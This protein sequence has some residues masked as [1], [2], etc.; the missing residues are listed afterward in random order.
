MATV[1]MK[2]F[3]VALASLALLAACAAPE[4][5]PTATPNV[6]GQGIW[7][8]QSKSLREMFEAS[9]LVVVAEVVEVGA[10]KV[11]DTVPVDPKKPGIRNLPK[12]YFTNVTI[13]VTEDLGKSV[14]P[15]QELTI[16]LPGG[17]STP[18]FGDNPPYAKGE[19]YLLFIKRSPLELASSSSQ[20]A[21][22]IYHIIHPQG[23]YRIERGKLVTLT[24]VYLLN[25]ELDGDSLDEVKATL[26]T[27][28]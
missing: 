1:L 14:P 15:S 10:G 21:Q 11:I 6:S 18:Y 3:V 28:R 4:S 20:D 7:A 23:R 9:D 19:V 24:K 8:N 2:L 5:A 16:S 13:R 26:A 12:T 17:G 22:Y 25:Q 27:Y